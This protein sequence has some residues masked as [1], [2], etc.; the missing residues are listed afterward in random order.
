[1]DQG[2]ATIPKS[3]PTFILCQ[4]KYHC[5]KI[6]EGSVNY[7]CRTNVIARILLCS[8]TNNDSQPFRSILI[9][10]TVKRNV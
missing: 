4:S 3:I 9:H 6:S 7:K 1:M 2:K 10:T 8:Q 5:F